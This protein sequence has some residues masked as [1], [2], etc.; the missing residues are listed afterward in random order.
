MS[1]VAQRHDCFRSRLRKPLHGIPEGA[2]RGG[3]GPQD[4]TLRETCIHRGDCLALHLPLQLLFT[5]HFCLADEPY[6]T[7]QRSSS[8]LLGTYSSA[9]R[10]KYNSS[11][12]QSAR[13]GGAQRTVRTQN[14][15][16]NL[17]CCSISPRRSCLLHSHHKLA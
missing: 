17:S 10:P 13:P 3:A 1:T 5:D 8:W 14:V 7:A 16:N 4:F 11:G 15:D 9:L 6:R 2:R 12:Q